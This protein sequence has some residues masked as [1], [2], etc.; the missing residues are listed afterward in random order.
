MER[1]WW[2]EEKPL[3][4]SDIS[5]LIDLQQ[6]C[7]K[8]MNERKKIG[9]VSLENAAAVAAAAAAAAAAMF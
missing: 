9:Q 5:V 7:S 4:A 6:K 8:K 2:I 3:L 1:R